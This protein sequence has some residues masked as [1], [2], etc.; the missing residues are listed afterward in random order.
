MKIG[1][2]ALAS[3]VSCD[4]LRFYEKRGLIRATRGA[5]GYRRYAP[6]TV[7]LVG[8]IRMAQR[9]GFSLAEIGANLPDLWA[10]PE[11]DAAIA[12]LLMDKVVTIDARIAEL[13]ALRQGL[14]EQATLRCPLATRT[15]RVG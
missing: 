3:A 7:Q 12:Q 8:Y 5:N 9:L 1:E 10:A 11:P 15:A 6:E 13:Q 4:A 2:L 14:L